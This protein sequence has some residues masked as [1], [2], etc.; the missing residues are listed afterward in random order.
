MRPKAEIRRYEKTG[1]QT[2]SASYD[3][4]DITSLDLS[5][6]IETNKDTF[7]INFLNQNR[8]LTGQFN[9]DDRIQIY[10]YT[11]AS[12]TSD[13]LVFDGMITEI[14]HEISSTNRRLIIRGVNRTRELLS[15]LVRIQET[16]QTKN[17]SDIVEEILAIV[18]NNNV[19]NAG[20]ER[21]IDYDDTSVAQTKS[22]SS[23]FPG[24]VFVVNYKTAYEAIEQFSDDEYTEDGQY[25]F[26]IDNENKFYW[27]K[28]TD[29][30]YDGLD[31]EEGVN[32]ETLSVRRGEFDVYNS[33][34]VA[35]GR[36]A[37]GNGTHILQ[38][39][40]V[41][42]LEIG[43][44]WK[45]LDRTTIA[46]ELIGK[47]KSSNPASFTTDAEGNF[48]D[49]NFPTSYNY[50]MQFEWDS[51][52]DG[53][54]DTK[55]VTSDAEFNQAIRQEAKRQAR[56]AAQNFLNLHGD[57]QIKA[58]AQVNGSLSYEKGQV[59]KLTSA[60]ANLSE[61]ELRIQDVSH[62]FSKA[63]WKTNLDLLQ[64]SEET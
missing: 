25:I 14:D 61:Q 64:D 57:I 2:W 1:D 38:I 26:Y 29:I 31:L 10:L 46:P 13:D 18:N 36:D 3:T 5:E 60:T 43:S 24:K 40:A 11:S 45:F 59:V 20:D 37:Y 63:G 22:D 39:N 15:N 62:T 8:D 52:G 53:T 50:N 55:T 56:N 27:R 28:K 51:D 16:D 41:S 19:V 21:Y 33:V 4:F 42:I 44:K 7:R 34:I 35:A 23:A 47:E 30:T 58:T 9:S 12:P 54:P 17:S 32:V 48:T 49:D 6:G